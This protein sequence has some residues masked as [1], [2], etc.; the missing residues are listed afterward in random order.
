MNTVTSV[1][2]VYNNVL[3]H[4]SVTT[5]SAAGARHTALT[6]HNYLLL[7][8]HDL[9]SPKLKETPRLGSD[10]KRREEPLELLFRGKIKLKDL[11]Y[12]AHIFL[13]NILVFTA[14]QSMHRVL[15]GDIK[16]HLTTIWCKNTIWELECSLK[17]RPLVIMGH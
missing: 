7:T 15:F 14:A 2:I 9:G 6:N 13:F 10:S 3:V 4:V 12:E 17:T 11:W 5:T 1:P 16:T 8:L